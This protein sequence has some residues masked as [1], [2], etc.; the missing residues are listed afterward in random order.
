MKNE[1][2]IRKWLN[3]DLTPQEQQEFDALEDASL[4]KAIIENA[5]RFKASHFSEP[6]SFSEVEKHL[7][8]K[9]NKVRPL[10]W[11]RIMIQIASV[12]V[13][14]CIAYYGFFQNTNTTYTTAAAE[15]RSLRLPDASEVVLNAS[16]EIEFDESNWSDKRWVALEGEAYFKVAKG[17]TFDVETSQG[18][19]TVLGTQFN[20]K[21]RDTYFEVLCYEGLVQVAT[22]DTVFKL[23]AG[24]G[25]VV[26]NGQF[27]NSKTPDIAPKWTETA[28]SFEAIQLFRVFNELERQ[29]GVTIQYNGPKK[30]LLF[31]GGF[32][33]DNLENALK[34]V[35][36]PMGL[37]YKI[38]N[39]TSIV[40]YE[41]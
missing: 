11:K 5:S 15:K 40:I 24:D 8:S 2:L 26:N 29:F 39:K 19:V 3:N 35:T 1:D 16:S 6:P 33:H 36:A 20:V 18:T 9:E 13:L 32:P 31:T 34:A 10:S 22:M 41:E 17:K 37:A 27:R 12:V 7:S 23:S 25:I 14:A 21:Q 28:S 4:Q 38:E 30:V